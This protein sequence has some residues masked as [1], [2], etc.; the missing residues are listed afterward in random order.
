MIDGELGSAGAAHR[1]AA[2]AAVRPL[3][4]GL[5]AYAPSGYPVELTLRPEQPGSAT[6]TREVTAATIPVAG[7]GSLPTAGPVGRPVAG[8][9]GGVAHIS[10]PASAAASAAPAFEAMTGPASGPPSGVAAA[11]PA[12]PSAGQGSAGSAVAW[13]AGGGRFALPAAVPHPATAPATDLALRTGTTGLL[14]RRR[15][16]LVLA[17]ATAAVLLFT[18]IAVAITAASRTDAPQQVVEAFFAALADRD[19][20]RLRTLVPCDD[21]PLCTPRAL[22]V[23][24][25]PPQHMQVLSIGT[26]SA[27]TAGSRRGGDGR[28]RL[29]VIVRYD[30]GGSSHEDTLGL[31]RIRRSWLSHTWR[32]TEPPGA[33]LHLQSGYFPR[34]TIAAVPVTTAGHPA[35]TPDLGGAQGDLDGQRFWAPPG[36]YT[37]TAAEDALVEAARL[38]VSVAEQHGATTITLE[39]HLKP[40]TTEQVRQQVRRSIDQCAAQPDLHPRL[41]AATGAATGASARCPFG[42][43]SPYTFTDRPHWT[44]KKYPDITLQLQPDG[45]VT[46]VTA[47]PGTAALTYRWSLDV[48]EPRTW[49]SDTITQPVTVSGQAIIDAGRVHWQP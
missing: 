1:T 9:P 43:D 16:R 7:P 23:G 3:P 27:G 6:A 47:A 41:D 46:V 2:S 40:A 36:R 48:L 28:D 8:T 37:V 11:G 31:T 4:P 42:Y 35:P 33:T 39:A 49:T 18:A 29:L 12:R 25:Q 32:I 5:V 13:A 20:G 14:R 24:Y 44:I 38:D 45:T 22:D 34:A 26:G 21:S 17:G 19:T 30:L 15:N 10:Y